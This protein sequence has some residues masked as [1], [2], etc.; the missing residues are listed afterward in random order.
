[1]NNT[2]AR[3]QQAVSVYPGFG[4]R[5]P[6][7]LIWLWLV[8]FII[9]VLLAM[10]AIQYFL[11]SPL[12]CALSAAWLRCV[13]PTSVCAT[14]TPGCGGWCLCIG[15]ISACTTWPTVGGFPA[16]C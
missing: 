11:S 1:M 15:C 3:G 10:S 14:C 7:A 9:T 6:E 4:R 16:C 8:L 13:S 12:C 5:T 2:T